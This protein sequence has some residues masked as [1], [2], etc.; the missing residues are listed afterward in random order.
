ML[1]RLIVLT[2][3]EQS[4]ASVHVTALTSANYLVFLMGCQICSHIFLF[5]FFK[6]CSCF[7]LALLFH[8]LP[9]C[10]QVGIISNCSLIVLEKLFHKFKRIF[11]N[12]PLK[13]IKKIYENPLKIHRGVGKLRRGSFLDDIWSFSTIK[14][15][16]LIFINF[17]R[18]LK[19]LSPISMFLTQKIKFLW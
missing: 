17:F 11:L 3:G 18:T 5:A 15:L 12:A 19:T 9:S 16:N 14:P 6:I 1:A 4:A 7:F 13:R 2:R 10:A 8:Y